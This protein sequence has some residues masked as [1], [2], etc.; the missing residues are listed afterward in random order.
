M[1]ARSGKKND[2][3]YLESRLPNAFP[4][5]RRRAFAYN[6][7]NTCSAVSVA[8][9]L[10]YLALQTGEPVV[11]SEWTSELLDKGLPNSASAL[12]KKYPCAGKLSSYL[13]KECG[14]RAASFAFLITRAFRKYVRTILTPKSKIKLR[15]TLF[16]RRET[17]KKQI[18]AG[19]PVL[20]TTT[21]AGEFSWHTMLVYGYRESYGKTELL[22]H[23][24]WYKSKF[25]ESYALYD[26]IHF[27][28][29][30]IWLDKK[31][32]TFAYY[33]SLD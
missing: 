33:F 12:E 4:Y 22:V 13:I 14:M 24:G 21:F 20:I 29:K 11:P 23:S 32:A 28:Q 5:I 15:W 25:N 17:I 27:Y 7:N 16:P 1:K 9:A 18:D 3:V 26:A 31:L 6:N 2:S 19:L 10:N 30:E 8:L